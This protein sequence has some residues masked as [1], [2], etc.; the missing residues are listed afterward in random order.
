MAGVVAL[1]V[2]VL[3]ALLA[4]LLTDPSGLSVVH[5]AGPVNHPPT[6]QYPLGTDENGRS[7][8]LLL[9]WGARTSLL[10]GVA[11]TV[12]SA[13]IGA[14]VGV[15]TAHFP[16]WRSAALARLTDFFLVLPSL[17]LASVLAAVLARGIGTVIL[18]IGVASWPATARVVRAQTLAV[19]ARPHVERARALGGGHWHLVR[20]HVLPALRPLV[21]AAATLTMADAVIT[22]ATLS[23]LG[24][25]DPSA[26]S[27]GS[28][29]NAAQR[30]GA[31]TAGAWWYVLPPGLAI[32]AL[33]LAF[34][35]CGR[36]L[37]AIMN[38]A[39]GGP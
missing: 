22:E 17:V 37:E 4:P 18:A 20:R 7:V 11:A 27:W 36:T 6:A 32:V 3:L 21:L 30:T 8:L 9:C 28:M 34:T 16:G 5:A 39:K 35:A 2:V 14:V 31:I 1:A 19:E 25:G 33:V 26:I 23:F 15:L 24:L 13:G 29:L 10:V 12:L 38:P